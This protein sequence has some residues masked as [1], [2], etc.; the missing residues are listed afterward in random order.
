M[1]PKSIELA[2]V[3]LTYEL[4]LSLLSLRETIGKPLSV[5]ESILLRCHSYRYHMLPHFVAPLYFLSSGALPPSTPPTPASRG[6]LPSAGS[7]G[8][9]VTL[10]TVSAHPHHRYSSSLTSST[11]E[12]T[13]KTTN[14]QG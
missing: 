1:N 5:K 11:S 6:A 3:P 7:G 9:T 4:K 14:T 10:T 2:K 13:S 12:D 8:T